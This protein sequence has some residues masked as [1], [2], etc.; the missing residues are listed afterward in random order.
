MGLI[1]KKNALYWI[2]GLSISL[3]LCIALMRTDM[4]WPDE[5]FQ[6]LEPAGH[7]VF[8]FGLLSW[9]WL[10]E[11]RSW[12]G[13]GFFVPLFYFLKLLGVTGGMIPVYAARVM[14]AIFSG[15]LVLPLSKICDDLKI[16]STSKW[17]ALGLFAIHPSLLL[18]GPTTLSDTII[19]F[20][21]WSLL[22][23]SIGKLN[24]PILIGFLMSIPFLF[25]IQSLVFTLTFIAILFVKSKSIQN[26]AKHLAGV[27]LAF[28]VYGL[29]DFF[30]YG[31]FL[32]SL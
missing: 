6:T 7:A 11:Y 12:I 8:G 28:L 3:R 19:T 23:Y 32:K 14:L 18:W 17:I 20:I 30:T 4:V 2:L 22:A 13:P 1:N 21:Y 16:N 31:T 15:L 24:R 27:L 29:V 26:L 9:E 5:H 10:K 25:K